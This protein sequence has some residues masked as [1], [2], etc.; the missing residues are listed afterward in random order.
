MTIE[1]WRTEIDTIDNELLRLLNQRA[2]L[3]AMIGRLKQVANLPVSD[4]DRE[5]ALLERLRHLNAGPLDDQAVAII[6]QQIIS[7]TIRLEARVIASQSRRPGAGGFRRISAA[8]AANRF[9]KS[10][11]KGDKQW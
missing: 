7:E 3:A 8:R 1:D 5:R 10:N 4:A 11:R 2:Q 6:F 9:W